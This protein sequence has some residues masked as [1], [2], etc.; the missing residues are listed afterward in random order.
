MN[1]HNCNAI[2]ADFDVNN[3]KFCDEFCFREWNEE[4]EKSLDEF[5]QEYE[6]RYLR[7]EEKTE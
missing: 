6:A 4:E 3:L 5:A 7:R 1:C 2:N